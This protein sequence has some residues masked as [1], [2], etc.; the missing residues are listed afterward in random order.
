MP[1]TDYYMNFAKAAR[2]ASKDRSRR[3]GAIIVG[4]QG[5][6]RSSGYN[7]FPRR[8]DDN[9]DTRHERPAKYLWTEHSERNAIYQAAR[10]G[11]SVEGCTMY[12]WA[13]QGSVGGLG[14]CADCARAIIQSGIVAVYL[15]A[16]DGGMAA[17]WSESIEVGSV[18]LAEA[19]V[20]VRLV[21]D[22]TE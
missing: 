15:Q 19:N 5:E 20:V 17:Q 11:I 21:P 16:P 1:S 8:V 10:S 2:L 4:P 7:G 6:L 3:V 12:T 18:M 9:V 22:S 13:E 14:V